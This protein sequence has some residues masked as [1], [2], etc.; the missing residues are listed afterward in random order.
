[1]VGRENGGNEVE[2]FAEEMGIDLV[3]TTSSGIDVL[4]EICE[5]RG[6]E[7]VTTVEKETCGVSGTTSSSEDS[8]RM[9]ILRFLESVCFICFATS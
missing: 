4:V 8:L 3:V 7:T 1:M 6:M 9:I 5:V 2:T